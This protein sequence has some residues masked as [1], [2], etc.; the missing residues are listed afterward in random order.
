MHGW[1]I[2]NKTNLENGIFKENE[3]LFYANLIIGYIIDFI[4]NTLLDENWTELD[5]GI[6]LFFSAL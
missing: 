2:H 1:I 6:T 4:A 5:D 3:F